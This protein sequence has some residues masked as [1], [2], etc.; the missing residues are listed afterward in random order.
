MSNLWN[1][2]KKTRS[3][4]SSGD[5]KVWLANLK[6]SLT[7]CTCPYCNRDVYYYNDRHKYLTLGGSDHHCKNMDKQNL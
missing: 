7:E 5:R 4:M 1:P 6:P 3:L 2:D